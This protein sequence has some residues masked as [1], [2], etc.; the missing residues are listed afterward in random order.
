MACQFPNIENPK[1]F[2]F[3][4][5]DEEKA[6]N[7]KDLAIGRIGLEGVPRNGHSL[8]RC[9]LQEE[10]LRGTLNGLRLR[11]I[12]VAISFAE[13]LVSS[14]SLA[15]YAVRPSPPPRAPDTFLNGF[16]GNLRPR[17]QSGLISAQISPATKKF[18]Q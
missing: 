5:S 10:F 18:S 8:S 14:V 6:R 2:V 11:Y 15:A 17:Q 7:F 12:R 9:A 3:E 1:P 16:P 4:T 13:S